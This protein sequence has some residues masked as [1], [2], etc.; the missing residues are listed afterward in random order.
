[1]CIIPNENWIKWNCGGHKHAN[2]M[3]VL[4][5]TE[6]RP[7]HEL[8]DAFELNVANDMFDNILLKEIKFCAM[9]QHHGGYVPLSVGLWPPC[10]LLIS[11]FGTHTSSRALGH[12]G[13]WA[14]FWWPFIICGTW[15]RVFSARHACT[16]IRFQLQQFQVR[17]AL[18]RTYQF[19]I[20]WQ[21][22]HWNWWEQQYIRNLFRNTIDFEDPNLFHLRS[23]GSMG[24]MT[25]DIIV[26][27]N[28]I[29]NKSI[30]ILRTY[31]N[32]TNRNQ[33]HNVETKSSVAAIVVPVLM[34][35]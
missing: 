18:L 2:E 33:N 6:M 3:N 16:G 15:Y 7:M 10:H 26:A 1:M 30:Y 34:K 11:S 14:L 29:A 8:L 17:T 19:S 4:N 25:S 28:W 9:N 27:I 5:E 24:S 21:N 22:T 23:I 31:M 12:L 32:T 13:T 35:Y 20:L